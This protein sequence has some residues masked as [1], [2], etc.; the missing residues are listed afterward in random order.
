MLIF[1]SHAEFICKFDIIWVI[2][3]NTLILFK[4][5]IVDSS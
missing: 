2:T 1:N 4:F 3:E 5:A